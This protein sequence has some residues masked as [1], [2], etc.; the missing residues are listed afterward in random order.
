M[1][2]SMNVNKRQMNEQMNIQMNVRNSISI[3]SLV[4]SDIVIP[5]KA[6]SWQG[7]GAD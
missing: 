4:I 3:T 6:P 1:N 2:E 5:F 7:T